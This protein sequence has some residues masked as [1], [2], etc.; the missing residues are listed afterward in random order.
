[1]TL[2]SER[3][4]SALE[5][6]VGLLHKKVRG[7]VLEQLAQELTARGSQPGRSETELLVAL[8]VQTRQLAEHKIAELAADDQHRRDFEARLFRAPRDAQR[9]VLTDSITASR[10]PRLMRQ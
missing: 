5:R 3:V 10:S 1:M 9:Q 6:H 8:V 7:A 2:H 4:L